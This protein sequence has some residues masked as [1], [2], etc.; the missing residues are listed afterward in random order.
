M[1]WKQH[2][3]TKIHMHPIRT[4]SLCLN[5]LLA[6]HLLILPKAWSSCMSQHLS[7]DTCGLCLLDTI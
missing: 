6:S 4:F 2:V 7:W 3:F 1:S 5:T